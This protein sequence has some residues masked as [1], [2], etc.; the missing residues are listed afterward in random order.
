MDRGERRML[1]QGRLNEML[2]YDPESGLFTR[3]VAVPGARAGT[4]AG[5]MKDTGYIVIRIDKVLYRS[6]RLAWLAVHGSWPEGEI[7]HINGIK[8]DNR[9]CNL[10]DV[11]LDQNRQNQRRARVSSKSGVLGVRKI[12]RSGKYKAEIT[13]NGRN[14]SLGHFDTEDQASAAYIEAKRKHHKGNTL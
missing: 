13:I 14:R 2:I 7:D 9:I 10:R 3:R 5:C 12:E 4:V 8:H 1:T 11:P 6:H